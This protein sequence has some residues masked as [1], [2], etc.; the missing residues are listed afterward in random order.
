VGYN[1]IDHHRKDSIFATASSSIDIWDEHRTQPTATLTWGADT[2][3]TV[4][5]NQ[6]ETSVLASAGTDRTLILYDLRTTTP[7]SK[8][9]T[10]LRTNAISWNPMEAFNFAAASEDHNVYIYDMRKMTRALN[11]MKDHV[12]AI[13]DVD[14][15]PTGEEL[16]TGSYDR[17]IRIFKTREGHSRDIY[18]TKRMQRYR[19]LPKSLIKGYSR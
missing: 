8:L 3:N 13:L 1:S 4:K 12:S 11:V 19:P 16:V 17:S 10:Q 14:F 2:I 5:F 9:V 18:H 15:S 7:I 6:T